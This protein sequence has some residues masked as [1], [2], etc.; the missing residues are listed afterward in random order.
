LHSDRNEEQLFMDVNLRKT[1]TD[2]AYIVVGVGVLGFQQA[3]VKRRDAV[4]RVSTIG[5]DAKSSFTTQTDSILAR[6]A[7]CAAS[8]SDLGATVGGTV[9]NLGSTVSGTVGGTVGSTVGGAFDAVTTQVKAGADMAKVADPRVWAEPVVGD[10]R[11]RVEPV[12]EQLRTISVPDV[13]GVV[14]GVVTGAVASIPDQLSKTIEVGKARVQG[15]SGPTSV[16][17]AVNG[18]A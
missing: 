2:T 10:L 3:Q 18:D 16:P 13:T 17:K 7:G 4:N 9:G 15:R 12:I 8:I 1:A 14:S 6:A 5:S 11:V